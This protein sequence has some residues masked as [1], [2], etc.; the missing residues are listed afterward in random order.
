[1]NSDT[2][3]GQSS[4][5]DFLDHSAEAA[6]EGENETSSPQHA[7]VHNLLDVVLCK[8]RELDRDEMYQL[9]TKPQ[10]DLGSDLDVQYYPT[11]GGRKRKQVKFQTRWLQQYSWE[12]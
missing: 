7:C 11:D 8:V 2:I 6:T 12:Y 10:D 3:E 9:L 5:H 4:S 1:M